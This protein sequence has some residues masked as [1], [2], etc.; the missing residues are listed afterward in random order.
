M[1]TKRIKKNPW[2]FNY[3]ITQTHNVTLCWLH[4]KNKARDWENFENWINVKMREKQIMNLFLKF[5]SIFFISFF[6]LNKKKYINLCHFSL[7]IYSRSGRKEMKLTFKIVVF[8]LGIM[9]IKRGKKWVNRH[10]G[11]LKRDNAGSNSTVERLHLFNSPTSFL[12]FY[13]LSH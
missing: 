9:I 12:F 4:K 3:Q 8:G 7:F 13:F 11:R 10:G 1:K 6:T 2:I 5:Y